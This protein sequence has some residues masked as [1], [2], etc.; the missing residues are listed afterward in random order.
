MRRKRLLV[1][2]IRHPDTN[3]KGDTL[4]LRH[5]INAFVQEGFFCSVVIARPSARFR[6][7][8]TAVDCGDGEVQYFN[9]QI[10]LFDILLTTLILPVYAPMQVR[11]FSGFFAKRLLKRFCRANMITIGVSYTLRTSFYE[12]VVS[13]Q[14]LE[15]IDSLSLNFFSL[16]SKKK[17]LVKL[18]TFEKMSSLN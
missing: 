9:L 6:S 11:I 10:G 14:V 16:S 18:T 5:R 12:G 8:L 7:S 1:L 17:W 4:I 2:S 15:A 3:G 13:K